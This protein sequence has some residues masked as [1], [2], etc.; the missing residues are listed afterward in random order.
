MKRTLVL[1]LSDRSYELTT[2]ASEEF[3]LAVI[4][5]IQNQFTQIKNSSVEANFDEILIVMLAN[6]VLNEIKY[7]KTLE[8]ITSKIRISLAQNQKR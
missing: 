4:N 1:K 8:K 3:V 6:S 5:R 2:D 7:E